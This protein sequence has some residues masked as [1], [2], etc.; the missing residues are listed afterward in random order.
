MRQEAVKK[1]LESHFPNLS[2]ESYSIESPPTPNYN[3]IAYAAGIDYQWWW[4]THAPDGWP[5]GAPRTVELLSFIEAFKS[6]GYEECHDGSH[7][8]EFEKVAFYVSNENIPTHA[9]RQLPSGTWTSKLGPQVDIF[10]SLSGLEGKQYG[11]VAA[12]LKRPLGT[13]EAAVV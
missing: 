10:H 1:A 13:R 2:A 7:E 9:A 8:A 5:L 6:L 3:C 4:P 12:F 11:T